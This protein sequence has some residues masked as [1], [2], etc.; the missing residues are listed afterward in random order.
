MELVETPIFTKQVTAE[1]SEDEYRLL[2]LHL[3]QHPESGSVI[4]ESGGTE[5]ASLETPGS[6]QERRGTTD[7]LLEEDGFA[8]LPPVSLP[9]E[10]E[11]RPLEVAVEAAAETSGRSPWDGLTRRRRCAKTYSTSW[12]KA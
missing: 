11:K 4:P 1:L 5:E 6:R 9:E 2:Q 7:L 8:P 10:R 3:S 12:W